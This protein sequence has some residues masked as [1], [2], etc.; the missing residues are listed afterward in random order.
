MRK[1]LNISLF[2][3]LSSSFAQYDLAQHAN[4][5]A[6]LRLDP[7]TDTGIYFSGS[8]TP[9][10]TNYL[11]AGDTMYFPYTVGSIAAHSGI[12]TLVLD[13]AIVNWLGTEVS[14]FTFSNKY[15]NYTF[16][17]VQKRQ[18]AVGTFKLLEGQ[19]DTLKLVMISGNLEFDNVTIRAAGSEIILDPSK[20]LQ[21]SKVTISN[22]VENGQLVIDLN[23]ETV[24]LELI[25]VQGE[26]VKSFV[27]EGNYTL[28]VADL[29]SGMYILRDKQNASFRKIMLK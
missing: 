28:P 17:D 23:G 14:T 1:I 25:S 15:D 29:T 7:D 4:L 21:S 26:V 24:D 9:A 2:L 16:T 18:D 22:P 5:S 10:N 11:V 12:D 3:C 19:V 27:V 13:I 8:I 20:G 6:D